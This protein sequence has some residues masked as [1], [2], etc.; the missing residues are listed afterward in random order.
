MF[1]HSTSNIEINK[2][3]I[4]V[5]CFSSLFAA[6]VNQY[7]VVLFLFHYLFAETLSDAVVWINFVSNF[8]SSISDE[9][10]V[11]ILVEVGD[12]LNFL[13][14]DHTVDITGSTFLIPL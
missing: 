5:V 8:L 3:K 10:C 4:C 9:I 12:Y 13:I 11:V 2:A 6:L 7:V 14:A 1:Q